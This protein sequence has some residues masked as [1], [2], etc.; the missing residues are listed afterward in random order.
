MVHSTGIPLFF[1]TI[2]CFPME[3]DFIDMLS[4]FNPM[5]SVLYDML[6]EIVMKSLKMYAMPCSEIWTWSLPQI[7][8]FKTFRNKII[9]KKKVYHQSAKLTFLKNH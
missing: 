5:L 8:E 2:L 7:E 4:D 1:F 3:C 6:W 9:K